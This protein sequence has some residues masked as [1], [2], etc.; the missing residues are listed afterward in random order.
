MVRILHAEYDRFRGTCEKLLHGLVSSA[1]L[2]AL[3]EHPGGPLWRNKVLEQKLKIRL[4]SSYS[5]YSRSIKDMVEA[6]KE[7]ETKLEI[8]PN[9]KVSYASYLRLI[10]CLNFYSRNGETITRASTNSKELNSV[11]HEKDMKS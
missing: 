1:E 4:Q 11:S 8:G 3:I 5:S 9:G 10:V 6:V 7:L 2:N